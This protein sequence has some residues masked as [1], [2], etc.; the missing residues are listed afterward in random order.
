[1]SSELK[2]VGRVRV[3]LRALAVPV[4]FLG[5]AGVL[6]E[7][8]IVKMVFEELVMRAL[9]L[10]SVCLSAYLLYTAYL[11][12]FRFSS[13]A[14]HHL[15]AVYSFGAMCLVYKF[16]PLFSASEKTGVPPLDLLLDLLPFAMM[17]VLYRVSVRLLL[18]TG[19]ADAK[20]V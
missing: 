4:G 20:L 3:V 17:L 1:M 2:A 8:F 12:W 5:L 19:V 10:L 9:F 18:K 15:C 13:V 14:V 7:L 6:G 16:V 11:V